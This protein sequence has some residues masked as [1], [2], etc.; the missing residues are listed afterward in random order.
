MRPPPAPVSLQKM[1]AL[2]VRV[3]KCVRHSA[4]SRD[5]QPCHSSSAITSPAL[6]LMPGFQC[7]PRLFQ[8]RTFTSSDSTLGQKQRFLPV[9]DDSKRLVP[10]APVKAMLTLFCVYFFDS[11]RRFHFSAEWASFLLYVLRTPKLFV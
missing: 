6:S 8:S 11:Q 7:A 2:N 10:R 1:S 4:W 3:I 9:E 5:P